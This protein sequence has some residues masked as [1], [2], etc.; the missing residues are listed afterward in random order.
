M[1]LLCKKLELA[2]YHYEIPTVTGIKWRHQMTIHNIKPVPNFTKACV[3][4]LSTQALICA[5]I[6]H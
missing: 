5:N 4:H 6:F 2:V 1:N 3:S